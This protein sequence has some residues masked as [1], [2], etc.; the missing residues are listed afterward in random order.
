MKKEF[1]KRAMATGLVAAMAFTTAACGSDTTGNATTDDA[2]TTNNAASTNDT[3]SEAVDST[4]T[5]AADD[6]SYENCTLTISWWGGDSR[7][8]AT[9]EALDLFMEKY[10]GITVESTYSAWDG[11]EEKMATAFAAG[12]A[13]DVNQIN[14]N[15]ITQYDADGTVF[16][17][18]NEYSNVIDLS[19]VDSKFLAMCEAGDGSQA[20]IP[21]SMTGRILYWDKTTFDEVG[22]EIPTSLDELMACGE[23]FAAYGDDYYPLALGE[24]DRMIFMVYYLESVYGNDWVT[25]D[26]LNYTAEQVTEGLEF[27]QSLEDAHVI[28]S[29]AT[30]AGD[31]AASLD[32]NQNWIDGHYAGIFEWDSSASKFQAALEEG[33]EFVVGDYLTGMGDYQGGFSKVSM[34]WAVNANCEHPKEAA[35]LVN[36]LMNDEDA[37]KILKSERGIPVSQSALAAAEADGGL[38]GI[39]VEANKKVLAYVSNSLDPYFEDSTL[40]SSDGVY[41]D[42]MA[43]LSYGDYTAEEAA[44]ILIDG[45]NAVISQ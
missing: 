29:I 41:Y 11:W 23:A 40:K 44:E 39:V 1:L 34:A 24:Y 31:G 8:S 19:Q 45:V 12:S 33:R 22:C 25:G 5:A 42:V 17:D 18:L 35:M 14:W 13:Q 28:P 30:I 6:G 7:H 4:E 36:F 2:S 20:G 43:G 38:D 10:P 27:I 9:Q 26:T 3:T 15:W 21:I 37:A 32:Q 16:L